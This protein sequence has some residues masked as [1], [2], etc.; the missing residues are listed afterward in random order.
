M[1]IKVLAALFALAM[2]TGFGVQA[3]VKIGYTNIDYILTNIPDSKEVQSKLATEQAQ[4]KKLLDE[5]IGDFQKNYE[6]YQKNAATMTPV[7]RQDKEK[8]LQTAQEAIQEF[9]QNS[10]AALQRKQQELLAPVMDKIQGAIDAVAKAN[11]YT[12]VLNSDAGYGTTP[13]VLVAPDGDNITDLV[14][15]QLGVEPPKADAGS[16]QN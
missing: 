4:Y 8:S 13:V 6:D 2:L 11:G 16:S 10:E 14:F 15:K 5:K 3:Q 12:Y 7:I 9:Q 1:K